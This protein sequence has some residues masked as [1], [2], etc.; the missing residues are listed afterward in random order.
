MEHADLEESIP[1]PSDT[2]GHSFRES[3][4]AFGGGGAVAPVVA[5][6]CTT[7]RF[8]GRTG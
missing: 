2:E 5:M 3:V 7:R 1:I 8:C 4:C 6:A